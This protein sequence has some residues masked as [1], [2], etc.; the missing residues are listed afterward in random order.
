MYHTPA[1][2]LSTHICTCVHTHT[3]THAH[4]HTHTHVH[5]HT[6][7]CTY[8]HYTDA[9]AN[10]REELFIQKLRQC[11]VIFDFNLDP[12]SDLKYKEVK[13]AAVTELVEFV[14]SQRNVIT[15]FVYP[16][17]VSMVRNRELCDP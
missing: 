14:T 8:T 1:F 13:R 15:E 10:T 7:T 5:T 4:A 11:C 12:L 17:A 9:Q 6:H 2:T 16:E 3:H